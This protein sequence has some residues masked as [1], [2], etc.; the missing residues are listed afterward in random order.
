MLVSQWHALAPLAKPYCPVS[1]QQCQA[2]QLKLGIQFRLA[3]CMVF[4][5]WICQRPPTIQ[6]TTC[7]LSRFLSAAGRLLTRLVC[8]ASIACAWGWCTSD[9]VATTNNVIGSLAIHTD[10][11]SKEHGCSLSKHKGVT[12]DAWA[13]AAC[14]SWQSGALRFPHTMQSRSLSGLPCLAWSRHCG[15]PANQLDLHQRC[16]HAPLRKGA[17]LPRLPV[18][19]CRRAYDICSC[20]A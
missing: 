1:S 7:D 20:I 17:P 18:C 8:E 2:C 4:W 16:G 15:C 11:G 3:L 13:S 6:I 9:N 19:T 10:R 12:G 14:P 5:G